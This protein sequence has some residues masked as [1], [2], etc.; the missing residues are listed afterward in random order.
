MQK[1]IMVIIL[2]LLLVAEG[3]ADSGPYSVRKKI[4]QHHLKGCEFIRIFSPG[5]GNVAKESDHGGFV[6]VMRFRL[7]RPRLVQPNGRIHRLRYTGEGNPWKGEA[8]HHYR[9]RRRFKTYPDKLVLK[10][11]WNKRRVCW[12]LFKSGERHG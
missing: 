8:R 5:S 12:K 10:G 3:A 4:R 9:T 7:R 1:T 11:R 6:A 2:S